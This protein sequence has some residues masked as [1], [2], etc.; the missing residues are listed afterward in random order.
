[1]AFACFDVLF[2]LHENGFYVGLP[3]RGVMTIHG[4]LMLWIA[5]RAWRL[6]SRTPWLIL[7]ASI[8]LMAL[9]VVLD[10][11][12]YHFPGQGPAEETVENLG[13]ALLASYLI[14]TAYRLVAPRLAT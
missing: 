10:L 11:P 13:A 3:E 5:T 9:A 12:G 1:M 4:A 2:L 14:L 7:V 6:G 8:G